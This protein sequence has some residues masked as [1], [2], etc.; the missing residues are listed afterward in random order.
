MSLSV[1]LFDPHSDDF[2][3]VE[4]PR[5]GLIGTLRNAW[6]GVGTSAGMLQESTIVASGT[7]FGEQVYRAFTASTIDSLIIR[8]S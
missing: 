5:R 2:S 1:L 3:G 4:S 6:G 7:D 8:K